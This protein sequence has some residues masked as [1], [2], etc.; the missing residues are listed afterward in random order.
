MGTD[1]FWKEL[2]LLKSDIEFFT[3]YMKRESK[4]IFNFSVKVSKGMS[5]KLFDHLCNW[6]GIN[7]SYLKEEDLTKVFSEF[8]VLETMIKYLDDSTICNFSE[9]EINDIIYY[10]ERY[11]FSIEK[12][13]GEF[14]GCSMGVSAVDK[15]LQE[16]KKA[17]LK[18][19]A[20]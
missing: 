13:I 18:E 16:Y 19:N 2:R 4:S 17:A 14:I 6:H 11:D 7:F 12:Y 3:L 15:K 10:F 9:E 1:E 20:E 8:I 5:N